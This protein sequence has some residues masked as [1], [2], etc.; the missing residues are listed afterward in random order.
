M[1]I[2]L[3]NQPYEVNEFLRLALPLAR[4]VFNLRRFSNYIRCIINHR[5]RK[6]LLTSLPYLLMAEP[7]NKCNLN[8]KMCARTLYQSDR[9]D[10]DFDISLFERILSEVKDSV[11]A[12]MLWNYGE[13]LSTEHIY[14][15][16][17]LC[18]KYRIFSMITTNGLL[19]N[20]ENTQKIIDAKLNYLKISCYINS[21]EDI[22]RYSAI[23]SRIKRLKNKGRFPFTDAVTILD[24]QSLLLL[25]E[26]Y[27]EL[28]DAGSDCVSYRKID[29]HFDSDRVSRWKI[30]RKPNHNVCKRL[31]S[32]M[33][34]NSDGNVYPCCFDF[35]LHFPLGNA[36]DN[37]IKDIWNGKSFQEFRSSYLD[38]NM[39]DICRY[40]HSP[41]YN[42]RVYLTIKD[43]ENYE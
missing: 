34:I 23:I 2:N 9:K 7:T 20:E 21:R 41:D 11:I 10:M 40:C 29:Y 39:P 13:P 36:R 8:C 24:N 26:I 43:L 32:L 15:M 28:K 5:R 19:L 31:Y 27:S 14:D 3:L 38:S 42:Q 16:I 1:Y 37:S 18:N 25:K 22:D 4:S 33:L 30:K 6:S 17:Q 12:A 35:R